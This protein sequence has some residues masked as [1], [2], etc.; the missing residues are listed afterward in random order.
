M[1]AQST[2]WAIAL[3]DANC[4]VTKGEDDASRR[5]EA[6]DEEVERMVGRITIPFF[7]ALQN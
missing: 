3:S 5:R 6:N 2:I 1:N 7:S 4:F